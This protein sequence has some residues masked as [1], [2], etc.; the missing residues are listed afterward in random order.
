[1]SAFNKPV[2]SSIHVKDG[3]LQEMWIDHVPS[4]IAAI[5]L[6]RLPATAL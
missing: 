1:M 3:L 5:F 2:T 4:T 6:A